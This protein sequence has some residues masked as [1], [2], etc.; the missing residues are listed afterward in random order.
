MEVSEAQKKLDDLKRQQEE[1]QKALLNAQLKMKQEAEALKRKIAEEKEMSFWNNLLNNLK[2]LDDRYVAHKQEGYSSNP[3][4]IRLPL[5]TKY[6]EVF[7]DHVSHGYSGG[8]NVIRLRSSDYKINNTHLKRKPEEY[9]DLENVKKLHES[10]LKL[11]TKL[12]EQEE[13][14]KDVRIMQEKR[15]EQE[16]F[17]H[18]QME[19]DFPSPTYTSY[20]NTVIYGRNRLN[21]CLNVAP[22]GNSVR[23]TF[24]ETE[25]LSAEQAKKV[26]ALLISFEKD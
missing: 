6:V 19:I 18:T 11:V 10:V 12:K 24:S 4:T 2:S 8:Y 1:A 15:K 5:G 20:G 13:A 9:S 14:E 26:L 23:Y 16:T 7:Q 25:Q 22:E 21:V 3:H 17:R